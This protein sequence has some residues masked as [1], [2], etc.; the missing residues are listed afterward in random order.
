VKKMILF[1]TALAAFAGSSLLAQ[2]LTGTWQGSLKLPN[3][4]ELRTVIKIETTDKDALKGTFYSIDQ[5]PQP[6]PTGP[7]TQQGS[8]MKMEIPAIGGNY[9]GKLSADG[10]SIAGTF[11]QGAPLPLNLAKATPETAWTI[12]DAPP[13]VAAM[14]EDIKPSFEVATIKPS[15]P[16][17]PGKGY[18]MRGREVLTLNTSV[19]DLIVFAYG[20]NQRQ[21]S[22]GPSWIGDDR[23][24][25]TGVPDNPGRPN[26]QQFKLMVQK[27]LA[28]RFQLTFHKEQKELS[29][30]V[31]VVAKT[32]PKLTKST[33][34]PKG[35]PGVGF[36]G[37]G[38]LIARNATIQDLA[39]V[40]QG[41]ALDRPVLDQTG[42]KDRWDFTLN[43][44]PDQSQFVGMGVKVP[45]PTDD[46]TAPPD[47]FSAIQQQ[48]GLKL[49]SVKTSV[50]VV[51][52]DKVE[53]PSEN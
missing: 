40:M 21:V 14:K 20:L 41:S 48:L 4:K 23:F 18:T 8:T 25:I 3:G 45:P 38:K 19:E 5:T 11:T 35:L 12:P 34:D 49:E 53:K 24:D 22:G 15:K 32:G 26:V 50:P 36:A 30:Y 2:S 51:V 28:D 13:P 43:W 33:A 44:T 46:P 10:K 31:V 7:I 52:I 16:G 1:I 47:L 17:Q 6:I 9:E 27:L 37:L 42:F 29:A 39:Q